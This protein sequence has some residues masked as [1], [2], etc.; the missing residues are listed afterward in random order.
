MGIHLIPLA[1]F[2]LSRGGGGVATPRILGTLI[3]PYLLKLCL[4]L[5]LSPQDL[6]TSSRF[7]FFQLSQILV[8]DDRTVNN[9]SRLNR[10]LRLVRERVVQSREV[11]RHFPSSGEESLHLLAMLSL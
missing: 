8:H 11:G 9:N 3:W 7:L 5:K 10:A 1:A 2:H 4:S 6:I